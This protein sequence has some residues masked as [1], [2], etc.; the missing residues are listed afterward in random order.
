MFILALPTKKK[1]SDTGA[2][3]AFAV[4]AR[5]GRAHPQAPVLLAESGA[6]DAAPPAYTGRGRCDGKLGV[7]FATFLSSSFLSLSLSLPLASSPLS[8]RYIQERA[9]R[10]C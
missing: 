8:F 6:A 1:E 10:A 7:V 9:A 3:C 4:C 5:W 2:R